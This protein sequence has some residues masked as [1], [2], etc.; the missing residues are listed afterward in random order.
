MDRLTVTFLQQ[1]D[2]RNMLDAVIVDQVHQSL[3]RAAC[4]MSNF[5][6]SEDDGLMMRITRFHH[7]LVHI[8]LFTVKPHTVLLKHIYN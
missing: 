8:L 3:E 1:E 5:R 7:S 6:E 4:I 2:I